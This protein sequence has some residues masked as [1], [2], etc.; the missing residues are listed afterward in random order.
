MFFTI[1]DCWQTA[2]VALCASTL[3]NASFTTPPLRLDT[4]GSL[5]ADNDLQI[6]NTWT[7]PSH[8]GRGLA[9]FALEKILVL[10]RKPARYFWYVVEAIN[11]PS[12]RVVQRAGFELADEGSWQ[13]P[14]GIKLLGSYV[15][16]VPLTTFLDARRV[17]VQGYQ[18][19][20]DRSLRV[21]R[22]SPLHPASRSVRLV[23]G[24]LSG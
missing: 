16:G 10:K 21:S 9:I 4:G 18:A 24:S 7:D 12:I 19:P 3:L 1:C 23:A 6:G 14:F 22:S 2:S 17:I 15:P 13:R 8:R 20:T 11:R 5:S